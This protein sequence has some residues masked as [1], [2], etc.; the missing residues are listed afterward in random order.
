MSQERPDVDMAHRKAPIF[1]PGVVDDSDEAIAILAKIENHVS[2]DI[3]RIAKELSYLGEVP[4]PRFGRNP[5]P[6]SNLFRRIRICNLRLSQV[7]AGQYVHCLFT[8]GGASTDVL[9]YFSI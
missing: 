7:F 4:P 2:V 9:G 3:V 8:P 6:G 5:V 1:F